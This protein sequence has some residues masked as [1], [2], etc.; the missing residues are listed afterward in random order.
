MIA[1]SQEWLR[2]GSSKL[3]AVASCFKKYTDRVVSCQEQQ[4]VSG[5]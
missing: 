2:D 3:S 1:N 4:A 5:S